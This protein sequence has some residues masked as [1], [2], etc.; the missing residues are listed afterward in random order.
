MSDDRPTDWEAAARWIAI[1]RLRLR[2]HRRLV[3]RC[4]LCG[5]VWSVDDAPLCTYPNHERRITIHPDDLHHT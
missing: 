2:G 5:L 1:S 4:D 3:E